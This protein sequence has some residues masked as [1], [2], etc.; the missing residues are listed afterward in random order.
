[1]TLADL[2][3]EDVARRVEGRILQGNPGALFRGYAIDARLA[4]RDD[5]FFA[6][7]G[8]RDGHDFVPQ[9]AAN[10]AL[11][12]VVSRAVASPGPDFALIEVKDTVRALQAL[13]RSV[14]LEFRPRV[15]GITGSVGKTTTKEFAAEILSASFAVLR[16]EKNFNNHLGLA[17]SLL[18]LQK[19]HQVAVLEMGM[20]APGEIAALARIA[21]P[22]VSVITNVHPVHLEFFGSLEGIAR[23]KKEILDGMKPDG[24]AVLNAD[25]PLVSAVAA[26]WKGRRVLFG[27]SPKGDV[28]AENIRPRGYEGLS[29]DLGY[30]RDTTLIDL[31]FIYESFVDDFLAAAGAAYA[32][33]VPLEAVASKAASLKPF[34]MR[35]VMAVL[36]N[37]V[38]VLDD[39]YNSNPKA[40]ETALKSLAA[41]PARRKVAVLGDMLELGPAGK[42]F[43]LEAGRAVALS[44]WDLLVTVGALARD[45]AAGAAAA[46]MPAARIITFADAEEAAR[47]L[48]GLLKEGDLVLV[49]GSRGVRMEKIVE[50]LRDGD[51][52]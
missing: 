47:A 50:L 39:S 15:V 12:A 3:L 30:G 25:D 22:D 37:G 5:L 40:L 24:T 8:N 1:M 36:G 13:G 11:G 18:R 20:S 33:S 7:L 44:G 26:G 27:R 10:G 32:L 46:G 48:A 23:A 2:R 31:P 17:L 52:E 6:V 45:M 35:G 29:F 42:A 14:L 49:K 28:R 4:G 16:S 43:H 38:R 21:P 9:A 34:A 19:S 51:K 41:L